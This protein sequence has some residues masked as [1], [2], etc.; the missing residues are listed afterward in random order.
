MNIILLLFTSFLTSLAKLL[1][2]S[3]TKALLAENL[4]LKQQLLVLTRARQRAP[5]LSSTHRVLLGYWSLFLTPRRMA[6]AAICIQPS[7]LL[8]FHHWLVRRK[9]Q[10]LFSS[11][12]RTK[13]GPKG[14]SDALIRAIVDLKRRNPRFGCPRIALIISRTFGITIDK[15]LVRRVLLKHTAP[16][17]SGGGPSWLTFLGQMKDSLWSVD[18]FRCESITLKSH[19]VLVVMDQFTRRLIGFG[20]QPEVVD[21]R[22]LCHMFNT[23]IAGKKPPRYLSS[24]HDPL[25]TFHRWQANLRI[26]EVREIKS[27]PTV[28][29]SH[30]FVER[31][32]GTIRRE[33]LDHLM[34]W[35]GRDL[36]RKLEDFQNYYN[37]H[38][39]H[40]A[41]GGQTPAEVNGASRRQRAELDTFNW[42]MHCHGLV[43]LPRAA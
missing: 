29:L 12:K 5:N 35:N 2:P 30:P 41:L 23:I 25:F 8:R 7:T 14:P 40:A 4:L 27:I 21:G 1:R 34:F 19:W 37:Y 15:H 32:I 36:E 28:P 20:V 43:Q 22:T 18:L 11:Q 16:E 13:P 39:G 31:V 33:F 9:Y 3:G 26:L 17:S 38:R 24:D 6:K 10:R 42:Q